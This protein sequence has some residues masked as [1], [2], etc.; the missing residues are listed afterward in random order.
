MF[1]ESRLLDCVAY[2]TEFGHQ[3][4]TRV[5][6]LRSGHERRNAQWSAPL[7]RYAVLYS[8]L[9]PDDHKAV[10][11]AHH[12]CL[13]SLIGFRFKDWS[14]FV[15]D[16]QVVGT[17]STTGQHELQLAKNYSFGSLS[18]SRPISKPISGSVTVYSN[19]SPITPDEVDYQTG[20]ITVTGSAGSVISWSG[21][22]DV[23]VRFVSDEISFSATSR[24]PRGLYLTADVE[25]MEIRV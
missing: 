14:D 21:E 10:I 25:L 23:P 2:G 1:N 18:L 12:A 20:I 6:R 13:G 8:N 3:Y 17:L 16:E 11:E 19:G 4:S 7:G 9:N 24:G 15:A 22:F 5:H